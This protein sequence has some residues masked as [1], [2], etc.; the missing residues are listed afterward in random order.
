MALAD[1]LMNALA[2][3]DNEVSDLLRLAVQNF[4]GL[5][6]QV[7]DTGRINKLLQDP[8]VMAMLPPNMRFAWAVK[9][10]SD[11]SGKPTTILPLYALKRNRSGN[12]PLTGEAVVEARQSF[13]QFGRPDISMQMNVEGAKRWKKL[14]S[15]NVGRQIA[16]VLDN[17]VY[18]APVVQGEIPNGSSSITGNFT[19]EEAQDLANVLKAGKLPASPRIVEEV[20]VGPS[21]G[22]EA[23]KQGIISVVVGLGMVV[24]FMV[25]YYAKGGLVA[26]AALLINIFFIF[27]ILAQLGAA[28]TLPGIAGIVLTIG[29]S[30]D[31][32]VLI[33]ERIRE[34]LR[35][36]PGNLLNAINQGYDRAFWTI[37]DS[38][39]TTLLT[40]IFLYS[41]GTGP[42][43]GFAVTLMI[44]IACSFFSAVFITRVIVSWLTAK[45][46]SSKISFETPFANSILKAPAI[47]FLSK[48]KVAY[49]ISASVIVIG[50]GTMLTKG[51]NLGVDFEGGRS[52][53]VEFSKR[54]VETDLEVALRKELNNASVE[55]KTFGSDQKMKITTNYM[56]DDNT[57]ESDSVVL[58]KL[59]AGISAFT[60]DT[61]EPADELM[62]EGKFIIPSTSKVGS[63][64]ADDL[65]QASESAVLFSLIAIFLYIWVRFRNWKFGLGAIV[66]L[67]HDAFVVLSIYAIA[68]NLGLSIEVDQVF[69]AALL[70]VIGYSIND[71]VVVFDRVR[72]FLNNRGASSEYKQTINDS[73]NSTLNRTLVTSFTTLLVVLILFLFG[74][75]VLRG[76]SFALLVGI[77]VGTYSSIFVATPV[78]YDTANAEEKRRLKKEGKASVKTA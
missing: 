75:E 4:G 68:S 58:D 73:I 61:Y 33:F 71:T 70:T 30:I 46:N 38:N 62:G 32:N 54:V 29:M 35:K 31:A 1:S 41:F 63:T 20:V 5:A 14:T 36:E 44:G 60:Q 59:V 24:V 17:Y 74:G 6:Y 8:A 77:M 11:Q 18:S 43:K 9:P 25:L 10:Q 52:Y 65:I 15:E 16:I 56:V 66:A 19:I 45:G 50:L 39:I 2:G 40:G 21:L 34:E 49:I 22:I 51:L 55:V 26:N 64:I 57:A 47:D 3:N 69:V 12:A 13:D 72:E 67:F 23:Q 76:F 48:R 27:G 42:V 78:V 53:I 28:L 7:Q 37:F